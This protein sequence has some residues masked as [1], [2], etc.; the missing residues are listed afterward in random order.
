MASRQT[1]DLNGELEKAGRDMNMELK[2]E[3]NKFNNGREQ[4]LK[5]VR[6]TVSEATEEVMTEL[7]QKQRTLKSENLAAIDDV[8]RGIKAGQ[9]QT[10]STNDGLNDEV[11]AL[12]SKIE[13]SRGN[14]H[15]LRSEMDKLRSDMGSI[16]EE[17]A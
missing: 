11:K 16:S 2:G 14:E 3:T 12:N 9:E 15:K 5:K 1:D 8:D 6:D 17:T 4:V 10:E 13:G 7:S